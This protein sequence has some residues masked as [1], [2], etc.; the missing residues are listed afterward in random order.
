MA[1][2][3]KEINKAHLDGMEQMMENNNSRF[4]IGLAL[5]DDGTVDAMMNL[6]DSTI[7]EMTAVWRTFL[8]QYV[9]ALEKHS[10]K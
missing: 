3:R 6:H 1:R 7:E 5:K 8:K 10:K 2:T 9:A 4:I